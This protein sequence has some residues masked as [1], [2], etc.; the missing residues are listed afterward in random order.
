V[1][2][3]NPTALPAHSA[4]AARLWMLRNPHSFGRMRLRQ[5]RSGQYLEVLFA[6]E[7]MNC[8]KFSAML[9]FRSKAPQIRGILLLETQTEE[10]P[11]KPAICE[12]S[13]GHAAS[14]QRTYCPQGTDISDRRASRTPWHQPCCA[15][16]AWCGGQ[17]SAKVFFPSRLA[18]RTHTTKSLA[19]PV[20]VVS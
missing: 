5:Q 19:A 10:K 8:H 13:T 11:I 2:F 12:P 1:L 9:C 14:S 4:S 20:T 16:S 18:V 7:A 3:H 6:D 17:I 15:R